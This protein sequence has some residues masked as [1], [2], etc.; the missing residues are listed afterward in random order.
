MTLDEVTGTKISVNIILS[1][2]ERFIEVHQRNVQNSETNLEI[3]YTLPISEN[4]SKEEKTFYISFL[5]EYKADCQYFL[6]QGVDA[7]D[8]Q[9]KGKGPRHYGEAGAPY[10]KL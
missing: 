9:H 1:K 10:Q 6:K 4:M 8:R 7:Y 3:A 5:K 2:I